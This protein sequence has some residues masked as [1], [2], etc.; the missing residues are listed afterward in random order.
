MNV[1]LLCAGRSTRY[2]GGLP[3]YLLRDSDGILM[4]ER[5]LNCFPQ[6]QQAIIV[7]LEEHDV[8]YSAGN[9]LKSSCFKTRDIDVVKVDAPRGPA[10][11]TLDVLDK[12]SL[13][14]PTFV[15]DCDTFFDLPETGLWDRQ[16]SGVACAELEDY[17]NITNVTS[18]SFVQ[19]NNQGMIYNV[20][21]KQVVSGTI[22][23]GGYHFADARYL[24]EAIKSCQ[25]VA[26]QELYLSHVINKMLFD[27]AIFQKIPVT[28]LVDVPTIVEWTLFRTTQ[29]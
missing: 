6:Y 4:A 19:A 22:S 23:V 12:L 21:E 3:K 1:I 25:Q 11:N 8:Q 18:K 17:T 29:S 2:A 13:I 16:V 7:I 14:G 10:G 26:T 24:A 28:N 9:I 5:A 20:A 27:G 15:K